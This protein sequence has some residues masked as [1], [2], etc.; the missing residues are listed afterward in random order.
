MAGHLVHGLL[1][2]VVGP[3]AQPGV[4]AGE[5]DLLAS[6]GGEADEA[7]GGGRLE[8]APPAL[9]E[10]VAQELGPGQLADPVGQLLAGQQLAVEGLGHGVVQPPQLSQG[11][12]E[13]ALPGAG[14]PQAGGRAG[15]LPQRELGRGKQVQGAAHGPGL[16]QAALL[17]QGAPDGV[18]LQVLDPG[19][20]GQLGRRQHLGVEPG[21]PAG[22]LQHG[23]GRGPLVEVVAGRPPGHHLVPAEPGRRRR[24]GRHVRRAGAGGRPRSGRR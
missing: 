6:A 20:Q 3:A 23:L 22:D 13:A 15:G 1:G 9:A 12:P 19:G 14:L 4:G 7:E 16:D 5:A 2:V 8:H 24:R 21:D 11:H 18:G 10:L 17:P